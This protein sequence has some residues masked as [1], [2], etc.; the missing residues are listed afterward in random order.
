MKDGESRMSSRNITAIAVAVILLAGMTGGAAFLYMKGKSGDAA[1]NV[2]ANTIVLAE[3]YL[4]KGEFQR[5]L[6]LLDSL[7]IENVQ[8]EDVRALRDRVI[9]EK[10]NYELQHQNAAGKQPEQPAKA[11]ER[12]TQ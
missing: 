7:L 5:S 10:Q 12:N 4:D 6:D 9:A 11:I 3:D 1:G 8:D 2:R